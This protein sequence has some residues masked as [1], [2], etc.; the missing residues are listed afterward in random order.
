MLC[1]ISSTFSRSENLLGRC[2]LFNCSIYATDAC[3]VCIVRRNVINSDSTASRHSSC[4][5]R[6]VFKSRLPC[7]QGMF[8]RSH[9]KHTPS[10]VL[11]SHRV[12]LAD[13]SHFTTHFSV[14]A[15][16]TRLNTSTH[17]NIHIYNGFC[18]SPVSVAC[19][20]L[21]RRT[22]HSGQIALSHVFR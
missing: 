3:I 21:P 22:G 20:R 6:I 12:S 11:G 10:A 18:V 19:D 7:T 1:S 15:C 16:I 13:I 2:R 14:S 5:S 17:N 8:L 9:L 4:S